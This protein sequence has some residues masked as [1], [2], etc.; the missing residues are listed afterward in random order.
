MD[1]NTL[2][3][4]KTLISEAEKSEADG[5][6]ARAGLYL[7]AASDLKE[8]K[9]TVTLEVCLEGLSQPKASL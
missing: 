1:P 6:G 5:H 4:Y 9:K 2:K 7:R 8:G 3:R